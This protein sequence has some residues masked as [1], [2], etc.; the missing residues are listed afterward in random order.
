MTD[1]LWGEILWLLGKWEIP[2]LG[3]FFYLSIRLIAFVSLFLI[4]FSLFV[5]QSLSVLSW[6]TVIKVGFKLLWNLL[7]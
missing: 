1:D 4:L 7:S 5:S 2:S 6:R 3:V